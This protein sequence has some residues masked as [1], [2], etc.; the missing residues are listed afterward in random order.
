MKDKVD[1][2]GHATL[3]MVD[4]SVGRCGVDEDGHKK[5]SIHG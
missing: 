2:R 1:D 3:M 5:K 4:N